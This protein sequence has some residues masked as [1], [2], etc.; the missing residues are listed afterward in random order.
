MYNIFFLYVYTNF[1][2]VLLH[3]LYFVLTIAISCL[4]GWICIHS[5][6]LYRQSCS[7]AVIVAR[8]KKCFKRDEL[9][10]EN[11]IRRCMLMYRYKIENPWP[12]L[13]AIWTCVARVDIMVDIPL[14]NKKKILSLCCTHSKRVYTNVRIYCSM[15]KNLMSFFLHF[16]LYLVVRSLIFF[17]LL[18]NAGKNTCVHMYLL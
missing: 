13:Q 6:I 5:I 9:F 3:H 4:E 15:E 14:N 2:I 1:N 18:Q 7:Y 10:G 8:K 17:T 11:L 16:C 12:D